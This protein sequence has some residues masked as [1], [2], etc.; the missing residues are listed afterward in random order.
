MVEDHVLPRVSNRNDNADLS[1]LC[2]ERFDETADK[3][4]LNS[5]HYK[6]PS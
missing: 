1:C 2:I 6:H 3:M 5:S 4:L